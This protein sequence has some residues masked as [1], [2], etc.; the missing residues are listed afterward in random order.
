MKKTGLAAAA[1]TVAAMLAIG[2]ATTGFAMDRNNF[3]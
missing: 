2:S 3:V 1:V